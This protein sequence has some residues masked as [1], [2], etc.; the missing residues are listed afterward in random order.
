MVRKE[1]TFTVLPKVYLKDTLLLSMNNISVADAPYIDTAEKKTQRLTQL[2][3][4]PS[5]PLTSYNVVSSSPTQSPISRSLQLNNWDTLH[6]DDFRSLL[7]VLRDQ[8]QIGCKGGTAV[9]TAPDEV[10]HGD[11]VESLLELAM[12][13]EKYM[14]RR[15]TKRVRAGFVARTWTN[16][17]CMI[18]ALSAEIS[19]EQIYN[20]K[21]TLYLRTENIRSVEL[22]LQSIRQ[23]VDTTVP[24]NPE[25]ADIEDASK[26]MA[27]MTNSDLADQKIFPPVAIKKQDVATH[28]DSKHVELLVP[29]PY[30]G[31][32]DALSNDLEIPTG[33]EDKYE[34]ICDTLTALETVRAHPE[35]ESQLH[36]TT[37]EFNP[38]ATAYQ[39]AVLQLMPLSIDKTHAVNVELI[40]EPSYTN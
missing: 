22:L 4:V 23:K 31:D 29:N 24:S 16:P 7:A 5:L 15:P 1:T 36:N 13:R 3:F 17:W 10:A 35:S 21:L 40:V 9:F 20:M 19:H 11:G 32:R 28:D 33:H 14:Q 34:R 26:E 39:P 6:I 30:Y 8:L 37:D 18:V 2:T 12:N 27:V 25:R 38:E